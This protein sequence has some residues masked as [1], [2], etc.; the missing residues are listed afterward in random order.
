MLSVCT[1]FQWI[2]RVEDAKGAEEGLLSAFGRTVIAPL[3]EAEH[4]RPV[5]APII[6][7]VNWFD[8]GG[9]RWPIGSQ[10]DGLVAAMLVMVT[11]ISLLV[12]IFS[13]EYMRGDR[14][15]THYFAFLSLF[16]CGML[17]L[18]SVG[19]HD[20]DDPRLG[21]HGSLLVHPDRAL[22]GGVPERPSRAEGVLHHPHR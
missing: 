5:V 14:R 18:V 15:Y 12:H 2:Q 10:V 3:A 17:T 4:H 16:T 22:V 20:P 11:I 13:L 8:I 19:Q 9:V 1:A 21:D 7:S 6:K